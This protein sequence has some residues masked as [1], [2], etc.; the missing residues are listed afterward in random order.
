MLP[1]LNLR[2][3][4]SKLSEERKQRRAGPDYEGGEG[5]GP[6]WVHIQKLA[7]G[8]YFVNEGLS[9]PSKLILGT[10]NRIFEL[11]LT[12]DSFSNCRTSTLY[13]RRTTCR[14][15]DKDGANVNGYALSLLLTGDF[16]LIDRVPCMFTSILTFEI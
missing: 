7:E 13:N 6:V 11:E 15:I 4:S 8:E 12:Q 1:K 16:C 5:F 2:G 9:P 10:S 14:L 3:W